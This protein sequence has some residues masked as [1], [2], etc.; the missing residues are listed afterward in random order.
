MSFNISKYGSRSRSSVSSGSRILIHRFIY[1]DNNIININSDN[2]FSGKKGDNILTG[3]SNICMKNDVIL[4]NDEYYIVD[5]VVNF[6]IKINGKLRYDYTQ[7]EI[8][9]IY[10]DIIIRDYQSRY[11][12]VSNE[13]ITKNKVNSPLPIVIPSINTDIAELVIINASAG[14][15]DGIKIVCN[16]DDKINSYIDHV[17]IPDRK[18][19]QNTWSCS[20]ISN[21]SNSWYTI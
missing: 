20:L 14:E 5:E 1:T 4:I 10:R 16:R 18:S 8:N 21:G 3:T 12:E 19:D 9:F 2:K 13:N 17:H 11:I 6:D 7:V 15:H